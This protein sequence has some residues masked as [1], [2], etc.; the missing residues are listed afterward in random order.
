M[1]RNV[2]VQTDH[3]AMIVNRFDCNSDQVGQGQ[4]L[5]DHGNVASVEANLCIQA[6]QNNPAP[7]IFDVGANIGNITTWLARYFP[8][9]QIYAFEP[10]RPVFQILNG[11]IALNNFYNVWTFPAAL[12]STNRSISVQEPDYFS[13]EDFGI[14]SLIQ[15]KIS[16]KSHWKS[17]VDIYSLDWF[18][19]HHG[20][21][22]LDLIKID[23]EGMDLEVLQGGLDTIRRNRPAVL[24]EHNDNQRSVKEILQDFLRPYGYSFIIEGNNMLAK[25]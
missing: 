16:K 17:V 7:V 5:L 24:I 18:M 20:I 4:W 15:D 21:P 10:Q 8:M 6:L 3:G 12:G 11:N 25:I 2:L 13:N 9:A 1:R 23:A 22:T 14:F 19:D